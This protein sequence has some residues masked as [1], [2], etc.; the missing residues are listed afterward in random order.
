M[1]GHCT[2]FVAKGRIAGAGSFAAVGGTFLAG[3]ACFE[4]WLLV[5]TCFEA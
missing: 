4:A 3:K 1:Q 2:N 5:G